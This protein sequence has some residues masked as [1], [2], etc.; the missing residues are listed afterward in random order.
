MR[1]AVRPQGCDMKYRIHTFDERRAVRSIVQVADSPFNTCWP[2][3]QKWRRA[4]RA[5]HDNHSTCTQRIDQS[6]PCH[7]CG[8]GHHHSGIWKFHARII[9]R[10]PGIGTAT[11][12]RQRDPTSY[13]PD[14]SSI[15]FRRSVRYGFGC[16]ATALA[17]RFAKW[18]LIQS[19]RF[20]R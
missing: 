5:G 17:F 16:L 20:R 7:A 14:A 8:S 4:P 9:I 15:N 11:V 12:I 6:A 1:I 3:F 10:L 2:C 18:G 13:A 19:P